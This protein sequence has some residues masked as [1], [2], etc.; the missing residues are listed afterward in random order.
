MLANKYVKDLLWTHLFKIEISLKFNQITL[1]DFHSL[2]L[3][4]LHITSSQYEYINIIVMGIN[5]NLC[6]FPKNQ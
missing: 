2:K 1:L 4:I 3:V 5:I 6:Q